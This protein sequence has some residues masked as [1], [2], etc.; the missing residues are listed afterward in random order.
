MHKVIKLPDPIKEGIV[1]VE[2]AIANRRSRRDY[3][4]KPVLLKEISQ[5]CWASQGVTEEYGFRA[6]PT[7]GALYPLWRY[8]SS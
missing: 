5:L 7:A 2:Q 3:S 4:D 1:S 6:A 8:T